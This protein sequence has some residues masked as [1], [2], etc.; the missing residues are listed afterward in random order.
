[1]SNVA[2]RIDYI[3]LPARDATKLA[4]V[5]ALLS[6]RPS[7]QYPCSL[8]GIIIR[9]FTIVLAISYYCLFQNFIAYNRYLLLYYGYEEQKIS[10]KIIIVWLAVLTIGLLSLIGWAVALQNN[11]HSAVDSLGKQVFDLQVQLNQ[12]SQQK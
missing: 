7:R 11:Y 1:M 5:K 4:T 2:N 12:K 8:V 10:D 9:N 6:S 3:K